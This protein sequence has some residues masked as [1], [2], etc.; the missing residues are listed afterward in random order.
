M[1]KTK[2]LWGPPPT[3]Y[4]KFLDRVKE[5]TNQEKPSICI[6]GCSDGKFVLPAAR[7]G[8]K[9]YAIDIDE[10]A[11]NGG[12]KH[13]VGGPVFMPGL[14]SR[15]ASEGLDDKVD[16]VCEDFV[17]HV[18]PTDFHAVF[19]S[20]AVNYS[21]N[22]RHSIDSILGKAQSLVKSRGLIY[23]DYMLP[24]EK[25]HF[26][27]PNYFKRGDLRRFFDMKKWEIV[28]DR[29]LPPLMEKAHVDMPL[30]HYHHWGH[31]LAKRI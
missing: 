9:V 19:T 25:A 28:Y 1:K 5:T 10:I 4:Y 7:K 11:I 12:D 8:F 3:R 15:L 26:D 6:L 13:G 20:G 29:V 18:F 27:R 16:V 22:L 24:L 2:S 17:N 23:F 30:D 21:Y 31:L 14:N